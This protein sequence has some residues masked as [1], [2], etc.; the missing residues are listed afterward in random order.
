MATAGQILA[1]ASTS[2]D[3][4]T[5]AV[6]LLNIGSGTLIYSAMS[7][8]VSD[9]ESNKSTSLSAHLSSEALESSESTTIQ[10]N[11]QTLSSETC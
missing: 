4:S 11:L 1:S 9:L 2:P 8:D 10:T 7:S 6:H 5:A 3:G